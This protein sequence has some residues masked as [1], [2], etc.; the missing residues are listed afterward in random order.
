MCGQYNVSLKMEVLPQLL[1]GDLRNWAQGPRVRHLDDI[2]EHDTRNGGTLV[3]V[4]GRRI[5]VIQGGSDDV[6]EDHR[7]RAGQQCDF[8]APFSTPPVVI[9]VAARDKTPDTTFNSND[10]VP[11]EKPKPSKIRMP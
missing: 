11:E 3:E 8:A 2:D 10:I 7:S 5:C 9:P 1:G 6:A 4:R